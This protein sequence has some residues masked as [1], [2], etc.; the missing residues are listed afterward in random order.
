M[1]KKFLFLLVAALSLTAIL[2]TSCAELTP[3]SI[4]QNPSGQTATSNQ[5]GNSGQTAS[6]GQS[7]ATGQLVVKITDAPPQQ[8]ISD[9]WITVNSVQVHVVP[10][11]SGNATI[12]P[13]VT[14]SSDLTPES[15]TTQAGEHEQEGEQ[16][17]NRNQNQ[18]EDHNQQ[19]QLH[20]Q[21]Q[22][23]D[24]PSNEPDDNSG[25]QTLTL[26][27][28]A[29]MNSDMPG[30]NLELLQLQKTGLPVASGNFT[31][32]KY[33]Q[34]RMD[35]T[36]VTIDFKDGTSQQATLPSGTLKFVQPFEI[37]PDQT[38]SILFDFNA[39]QSVNMTGN[40]KIIFKPVIKLTVS[41]PS[42]PGT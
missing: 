27:S 21:A 40:G 2:F 13:T 5:P 6:P 31:A 39:L 19:I 20:Q 36:S 12:T 38:T 35:V 18:N 11:V 15:N 25:W 26:N 32:G 7:G 1:N 8:D 22:T 28:S 34:I 17:N 9:I 41:P 23:S 3:S 16:N 4:S 42:P 33:T 10:A 29:D 30:I 14:P 37:V 24:A